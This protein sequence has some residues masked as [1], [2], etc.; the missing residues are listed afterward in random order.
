MLT[1]MSAY[2]GSVAPSGDLGLRVIRND[3]L[4]PRPAIEWPSNT[5]PGVVRQFGLPQKGL[6]DEIN[7]W[8][9]RNIPNLWRGVRRVK[10]AKRLGIPTY[11][12]A[13]FITK[14]RGDGE[15]IPYGLA[16]MRV[17]TTVGVGYIV[18]AFQNIVEAEDQHFHAYGTG[19]TAENVADTDMVTEMTTQYATDNIRPTG[20]TTEGASANIYRTVATFS[21][22]A[23][24]TIAVVE[25][26]IFSDADVGQGVLL[27]RSVFAAVNVV[28]SADSLQT[29]YELTFPAGS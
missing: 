24:G 17:V 1:A 13:L 8:R 10:M 3:Q 22:N 26:G 25:H 12:G 4:T 2:S 28:A 23:G 21:P 14:I 20:T 29:T 19:S 7:T 6:S 18:D 11:Y 16:S 15:V 9:L 27:D 5:E